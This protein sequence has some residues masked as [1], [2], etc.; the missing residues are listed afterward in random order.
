VTLPRG[1][2]NKTAGGKEEERKGMGRDTSKVPGPGERAVAR[3][4][5][6][7]LSLGKEKGS[8]WDI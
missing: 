3:H 7:R 1:S 8:Y 5:N 4:G 2:R 6:A